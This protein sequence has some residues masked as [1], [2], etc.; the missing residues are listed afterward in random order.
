MERFLWPLY[1]FKDHF[2]IEMYILI[3]IIHAYDRMNSLDMYD[4]YTLL[5][6]Y[7]LRSYLLH[8]DM[9]ILGVYVVYASV[10]CNLFFSFSFVSLHLQ[11][12]HR[13]MRP[14]KVR[15]AD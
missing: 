2:G 12:S 5:I 7:S 11:K 6:E 14:A 3:S 1:F 8:N 4:E 15:R 10:F 13:K 9:V